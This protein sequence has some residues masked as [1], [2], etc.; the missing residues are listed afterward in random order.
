MTTPL[1]RKPTGKLAFA[2]QTIATLEQA[3]AD[4]EADIAHKDA[5]ADQLGR[6]LSKSD[7][8]CRAL[9][10]EN[11]R[12]REALDDI[13]YRC[14]IDSLRAAIDRARSVLESKP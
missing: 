6:E 9:A 5:Y 14:E 2:Y 11:K 8:Q 4:L 10:V 7:A 13:A 1:P 12:L 3:R